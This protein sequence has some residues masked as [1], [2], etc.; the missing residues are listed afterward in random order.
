[1]IAKE[2]VAVGVFEDDWGAAVALDCEDD[3]FGATAGVGDFCGVK[4]RATLD[5]GTTGA[6][7]VI[8]F[9]ASAMVFTCSQVGRLPI[10][11]PLSSTKSRV[12]MVVPD[13]AKADRGKAM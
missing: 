10:P 5:A 3:V 6:R 2:E 4:C 9:P 13:L 7:P 1:M 12:G 8:S 11:K